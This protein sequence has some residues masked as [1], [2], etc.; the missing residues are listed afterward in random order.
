MQAMYLFP[1]I[2]ANIQRLTD[3]KNFLLLI[4]FTFHLKISI[5]TNLIIIISISYK[6]IITKA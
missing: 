5:N 6:D 4:P 2:S 3:M 1:N